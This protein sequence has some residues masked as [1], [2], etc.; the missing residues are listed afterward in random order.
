MKQKAYFDLK[1]ESLRSLGKWAADCAERA[2]PIYEG[3]EAGDRRPREA[4]EGIRAF[5]DGGKR[6][7]KLRVL[8]LEAYRASLAVKE[9]AASAAAQAAGLAAASAYTHPLAD[10]QQTK[11]VLGPA[12]YAAWA[13][14][15]HQYNTP[16]YSDDEVRWAIERVP[17]DVCEILLNMPERDEGKTRLD[18]L[19]YDLD[20][21]LRNKF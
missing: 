8:A 2:L 9:P 21:G 7:A 20:R 12:A 19:M 18:K 4:I 16:R 15:L 11:H 5:A 13:L 14:E 6:V 3:L 17:K 1:L 10:I